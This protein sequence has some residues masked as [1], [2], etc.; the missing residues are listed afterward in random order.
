MTDL[1]RPPD[2][3]A[4]HGCSSGHR[5]RWRTWPNLVTAARTAAAVALVAASVRDGSDVLLFCGLAAYWLGDIAD[6][7]VARVIDAETRTG[8]VFDIL[9]DR[10]CA[11]VFYLSYAYNHH[12]MVVPIALFLVN[13]MLV[14]NLLSLGFLGWPLLSPNY[15]YLVDRTVYL[16]NWSPVA[17]AAN[18]ALMLAVILGTRSWIAATLV[19]T[20]QLAVKVYSTALL[21]RLHP[22]YAA[23][24]VRTSAAQ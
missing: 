11:G 15:F 6:G 14:D 22:A 8:A 7:V 10:L 2:R 4:H 19:A 16:L 17:K 3:C 21:A 20:A 23:G 13:F 18:G 12:D 5:D 24:C 9:A 1:P